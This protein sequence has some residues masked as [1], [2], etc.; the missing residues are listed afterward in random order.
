MIVRVWGIVNS[1]EIEFSPVPDRP[2]YYEGY[3]KSV[4][5]LQSIEIWA[6]NDKGAKGHL[7]CQ[8]LIEYNTKTSAR[9]LLAPYI[10]RLVKCRPLGRV[11]T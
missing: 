7:K 3:A 11:S 1:E 2:D 5:G 9:L 10:V 8:V 4:E 6:E